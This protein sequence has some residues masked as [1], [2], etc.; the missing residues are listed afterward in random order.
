[1]RTF[2]RLVLVLVFL[3]CGS[4]NSDGKSGQ[5][6]VNGGNQGPYLVAVSEGADWYI[7]EVDGVDS[8]IYEPEPEGN[9]I[10]DLKDT[11]TAP[12]K[13]R[14]VLKGENLGGTSPPLEFFLEYIVQR[15]RSYWSIWPVETNTDP[16]YLDCFSEDLDCTV[17]LR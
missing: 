9:L 14:C 10:A 3:G 5:G 4:G 7:L 2:F 12:G 17:K 8:F 16:E 13:Y 6:G 1:M 15:G 11:L